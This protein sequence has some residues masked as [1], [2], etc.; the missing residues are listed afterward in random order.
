M[1]GKKGSM[2]IYLCSICKYKV[3]QLY[4]YVAFW[5]KHR[6]YKDTTRSFMTRSPEHAKSEIKLVLILTP[7]IV[8]GLLTGECCIWGSDAL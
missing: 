7:F 6:P 3:T 5:C 1:G 2:P 8:I 4:S